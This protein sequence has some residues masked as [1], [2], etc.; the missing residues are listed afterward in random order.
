[1]TIVRKMQAAGI[2]VTLAAGFMAYTAV[3]RDSEP[4]IR[5]SPA[6]SRNSDE[7][8]LLAVKWE[9]G[10]LSIQHP[11]NITASVDGVPLVSKRLHVSPWSETMSTAPGATVKLV[12][13]TS[14]PSVFHMDCILMRDGKT[15]PSTG[16]DSIKVPG[17]VVCFN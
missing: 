5:P 16:Y 8:W 17:Q 11:V 2:L 13:S 15:I 1:M 3:A 10:V 7:R 12:A 9:P 14:H 6:V 4:Q